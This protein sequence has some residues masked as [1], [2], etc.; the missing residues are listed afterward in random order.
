MIVEFS[1]IH[2][3]RLVLSGAFTMDSHF[4]NF[5]LMMSV[6]LRS[7]WLIVVFAFPFSS[8]IRM[9][10]SYLERVVIDWIGPLQKPL[11][12]PPDPLPFQNSSPRQ[13]QIWLIVE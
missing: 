13:V 7:I 5:P 10:H 8:A 2:L 6:F 12:K 3:A 9:I 1:L 4:E 11:R